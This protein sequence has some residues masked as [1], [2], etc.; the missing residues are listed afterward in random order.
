M[1]MATTGN[2]LREAQRGFSLAEVVV[3]LGILASVLISVA[4]LLVV[5]NRLV[6][7]GRG[8]SLALAV[9][10]DILEE[11]DGRSFAGVYEEFGCDATQSICT[12]DTSLPVD[13]AMAQ[14]KQMVD[15][16]LFEGFVEVRIESVEDPAPSLQESRA[17][18]ISVS[19][20][21]TEGPRARNARLTTVRM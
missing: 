3:A 1:W 8:S 16:D 12:I 7:S 6:K 9:A 17:L 20:F 5:G 11:C 21:W 19:V 15:R 2:R 10:R 14:W 13:P 18:R 4:G